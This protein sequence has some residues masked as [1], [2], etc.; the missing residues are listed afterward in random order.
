MFIKTDSGCIDQIN[1][2]ILKN[3]HDCFI[4]LVI[5]CILFGLSEISYL[6]QFYMNYGSKSDANNALDGGSNGGT[7]ADPTTQNPVQGSSSKFWAFFKPKKRA[8]K[9]LEGGLGTVAPPDG[10]DIYGKMLRNQFKLI[11]PIK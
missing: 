9:D 3:I 5:L 10:G 2:R 1:A 7:G 11:V 6:F 4:Y 8:K